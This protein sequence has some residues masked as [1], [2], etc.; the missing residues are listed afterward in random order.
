MIGLLFF[1]LLVA[2]PIALVIHELGHIITGALCG[3]R[4]SVLTIGTGRSIIRI[5][6]QKLHIIIGSLFF[7]GGHSINVKEPEFT[8]L[9]KVLISSGGPLANGVI[10][11]LL[12]IFPN[13]NEIEV[14]HLFFL[15]NLYLAVVNLIPFRIGERKSDGY[16]ILK[17]L[18]GNWVES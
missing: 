14:I 1:L 3:A 8:R 6:F 12:L 2:A 17:N 5:K 7:I 13:S 15:F 16:L 9:Q 4:Y 18:N 11:G 10:C